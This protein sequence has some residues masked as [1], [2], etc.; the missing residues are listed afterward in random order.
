MLEDD[1]VSG[2]A[3]L[4]SSEVC[5]F[6]NSGRFVVLSRKKASDNVPQSTMFL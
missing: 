3:E 2:E 6:V 5:F 1:G 4:E